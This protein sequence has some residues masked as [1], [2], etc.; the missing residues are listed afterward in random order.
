MAVEQLPKR[1]G[2]D[3]GNIFV[4]APYFDCAAL[5]AELAQMALDHGGD[6]A[7]LRAA[8][9]ARF[10]ELKTQAF[11]S[12]RAMLE[13]D[14]DGRQCARGLSRFHDELIA[15]LFDFARTHLYPVTNP[16]SAE[17]INIAATGGYGRGLMAPYSDVDLLILLPYKQTAWGESM[18]EFILY[19]LWDLGLKVGHAVRTVGQCMRA[20]S[21]DMTIR[22]ALLDA[23]FV[24]GDE[25]LFDE[26]YARFVKDV[27]KGNS[28]A[29]V[30][31]KLDERDNRLKR[32]GASRYSVEPN[33]KEGKGALRD[34]HLLHWLT[35]DIELAGT[36]DGRGGEHMLSDEERA[37]YRDCEDFLWTV[38]CHPAWLRVRR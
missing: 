33:I 38:R 26:F 7:A 9:L 23:R 24:C 36:R 10:K 11:A 6:E 14:N 1:S 35:R 32:S 15:Q 37:T 18:V 27:V 28:Q 19:M 25:S 29:F 16:S 34:L 17:R 5:R 30:E 12:A 20:A 31:A 21:E 3:K 4:P 22:T 2:C 8:L 13:E